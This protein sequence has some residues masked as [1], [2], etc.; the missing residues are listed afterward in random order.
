MLFN[1]SYNSLYLCSVFLGTQSA[2]HRRVISASTTNKLCF[3]TFLTPPQVGEGARFYRHS[4]SAMWVNLAWFLEC[5]R[6]QYRFPS[7]TLGCFQTLLVFSHF[8]QTLILLW[9]KGSSRFGGIWLRVWHSSI[10]TGNP[11]SHPSPYWVR[12]TVN[13]LGHKRPFRSDNSIN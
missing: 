10:F 11:G 9:I 6:Q 4:W 7:G 8:L 3:L 2:L 5:P 13:C 12:N 1:S